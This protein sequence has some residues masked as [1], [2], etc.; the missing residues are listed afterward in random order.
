MPGVGRGPW[1]PRVP[2]AESWPQARESVGGGACPLPRS[3]KEVHTVGAPDLS[4]RP[5]DSGPTQTAS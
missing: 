1:A 2:T 3:L 5:Q 4:Q